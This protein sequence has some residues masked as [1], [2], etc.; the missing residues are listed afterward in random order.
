MNCNWQLQL[1]LAV[2]HQFLVVVC[3]H[4]KDYVWYQ[5]DDKVSLQKHK[6][7]N[8][9][10]TS[11]RTDV[12]KLRKTLRSLQKAALATRRVCSMR[13]LSQ[14]SVAPFTMGR[15][16]TALS[17]EGVLLMKGPD[18]VQQVPDQRSACGNYISEETGEVSNLKIATYFLNELLQLGNHTAQN[19]MTNTAV[20]NHLLPHKS[21]SCNPA[22]SSTKSKAAQRYS[23]YST[24][25]SFR[26]ISGK[27]RMSSVDSSPCSSPSPSF[28]YESLK[29]F[30]D[31][32]I[33]SMQRDCQSEYWWW[34]Q[35]DGHSIQQRCDS[36]LEVKLWSSLA[37]GQEMCQ[38]V[39]WRQSSDAYRCRP[40]K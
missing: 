3:W 37:E 16:A 11:L 26:P 25:H 29:I 22:F 8:N 14:L 40:R 36:I 27:V 39:N 17:G 1:P 7:L 13:P 20:D 24:S 15:Q 31:I 12:E 32:D 5:I 19:E 38:V 21:V 10:N 33:N 4:C 18:L 2:L 28:S 6:E 34:V 35:H 30:A 9:E 23:P